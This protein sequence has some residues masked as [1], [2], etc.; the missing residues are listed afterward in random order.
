MT[1]NKKMRRRVR[2]SYAIS[3][4]SIAFVLFL[5]ASVGFI[6]WNLSKTTDTI[7]E[8]MTL[9]VMLE[10]E[11]TPEEAATI[12][13]KLCATE[14]IREVIFVPKGEA[15]ADF[16][17][18]A[19]GDFE[20]FL[21]FN[22]LPDSYEVK[23]AS[24]ESPKCLVESLTADISTWERVDE[25]VYQ[26]GMVESLETNLASF[27]F[28]MVVFAGVML[29]ISLVLLRN[30]VRMSVY[31]RREVIST[32]KLVGAS[33]LFIKR[34]FLINSIWMGLLAGLIA[35]LMFWGVL[36]ALTKGLSYLMLTVSWEALAIIFGSI[37]VGGVL[38]SLIFTYLSVSRFVNMKTAKIHIY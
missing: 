13:E 8:R 6:I 5:V 3:T 34:P 1:S 35:S 28:M 19:G 18:Y 27:K 16:K 11:T 2:G 32:M 33:R 24:C 12:G 9:Y 4:I 14:G 31:S 29:F 25:V 17:Q 7:K 36:V 23:I 30:T 26:K 38:I 21:D 37:M 20:E 15:A 10:S 22:P